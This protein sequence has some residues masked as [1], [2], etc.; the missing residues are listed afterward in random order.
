VKTPGPSGKKPK[1]DVALLEKHIRAALRQLALKKRGLEP[2]G[3]L[4]RLAGGQ[5]GQNHIY[6]VK[7]A[8]GRVVV[9]VRVDPR[10]DGDGEAWALATLPKNV[11]PRLLALTDP[12]VLLA[13]AAQA[14]EYTKLADL[15]HPTGPILIMEEKKGGVPDAFPDQAVLEAFCD[16]YARMFRA[17][18]NVGVKSAKAQ[19]RRVGFPCHPRIAL[20]V[21]ESEVPR[22]IKAGWV[23]KTTATALRASLRFLRG[24]ARAHLARN[25]RRVRTLCHGDLRWHNTLLSP[26]PGGLVLI[27]FEH[28]GI[29]DPAA[30]L[31]LMACRT[32][33]SLDGEMQILDGIMAR[34]GDKDLH[35]RFFALKPMLGFLAGLFAVEDLVKKSLGAR[36]VSGEKHAAPKSRLPLVAEELH[37]ALRRTT[38]DGALPRIRLPAAAPRGRTPRQSIAVDGTALSGKSVIASRVARA[39]GWPHLNS[40]TL[41]RYATLVALQLGADWRVRKDHQKVM[42]RLAKVQLRLLPDG[43]LQARG[44]R[45]DEA[46]HVI[47]VSTRVAR[48]A[49]V[50]EI[51]QAM[52]GVLAE[53]L[54]KGPAVVEG[55]AIARTHLS[56]SPHRFFV[57]AQL[58]TRAERWVKRAGR[59]LTLARA[60]KWVAERD[61]MDAERALD[62]MDSRDAKHIVDTTRDTEEESLIRVMK[63]LRI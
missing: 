40:G 1:S 35:Q 51:R 7:T 59:N 14:G 12:R 57:D 27:D 13:R 45:W 46:L 39:L 36:K 17:T 33:L 63:Q 61:R 48:W 50:P 37:D 3:P 29:G 52:D 6:G 5:G 23:D 15:D 30:D 2:R 47:E 62:P 38:R 54:K 31:A 42:R 24:H 10:A 58:E 44:A 8:D 55:R 53:E 49:Q 20:A 32:P 25:F 43:S 26:A 11:A 21:A 22:F 4:K 19:K 60:K 18:Q 56:L 9:K 16:T 28:A 41:Y 34:T